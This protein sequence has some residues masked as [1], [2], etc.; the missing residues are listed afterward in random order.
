M[1]T[2]AYRDFEAIRA[3]E[4]HGV[5]DVRGAGALNDQPRLVD[6]H[7]VV[8]GPDPLIR[9]VPRSEDVAADRGT[10][11]LESFV[12]DIRLRARDRR[13]DCGHGYLLI[14]ARRLAEALK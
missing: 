6:L 9:L 8:R 12:R 2:T 14:S 11:L 1:S 5:D 13:E 3:R 4:V 10:E 7:G